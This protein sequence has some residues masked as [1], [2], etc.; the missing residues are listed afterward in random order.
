MLLT[1]QSNHHAHYFH[2]PV[3][4]SGEEDKGVSLTNL[5]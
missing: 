4:P 3:T 5:H 1:G 2:V